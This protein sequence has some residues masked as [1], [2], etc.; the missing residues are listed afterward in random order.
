[1]TQDGSRYPCT[2][3][4]L[5]GFPEADD[6]A[7]E[8]AAR[9]QLADTV[10]GGIPFLLTEFR[11]LRDDAAGMMYVRFLAED[12]AVA[13]T[14]RLDDECLWKQDVFEMFI[15]TGDDP[16]AYVELEA[17]PYD[18]RFTGEIRGGGT[19][20]R[21]LDMDLEVPGFMTKTRYYPQKSQTVSV[22]RI[23]YSAFAHGR[24]PGEG[25]RVNLFR[26]D[27]SGRGVDLQAW[28]PTGKR[29]FHVPEKF[30]YF[31]FTA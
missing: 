22:W 27:Y 29:D 23:P 19:P 1:M 25:I 16:G 20:Q 31:D 17:S 24:R 6:P 3:A 30:G 21:T 15:G 2:N 28:Q 26:V 12:D 10:T 5:P 4:R 11:A 13:A 7:W 18:V 14:F 8:G 9:A